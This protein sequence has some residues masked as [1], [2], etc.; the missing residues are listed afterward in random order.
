MDAMFTIVPIF[1]GAV[2]LF[3]VIAFI[4]M[5]GKGVAEWADNNSKPVLS[6]PARVVARRAETHTHNWQDGRTSTS[7]TYYCTY[8]LEN[9]ERME[10]QVDAADYGTLADGDVGVLTYQGTR[11]QGFQRRR[12]VAWGGRPAFG[13][14][15]HHGEEG[16]GPPQQV[17]VRCRTCQALNDET[18]SFCNRCGSRI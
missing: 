13:A 17:K 8:E 16:S 1:I 6:V 5:I 3:I 11:F 2:F 14:G 18:A 9:R 12:D 4:V 15:P 7:T 10:L